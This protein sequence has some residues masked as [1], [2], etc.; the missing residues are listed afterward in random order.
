MVLVFLGHLLY[1]SR[2]ESNKNRLVELGV[3]REAIFW[4]CFKDEVKNMK[5]NDW[6]LNN[7]IAGKYCS[8]LADESEEGRLM[9]KLRS[10][11]PVKYLTD[12]ELR[13]KILEEY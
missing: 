5:S 12:T 13:I 2:L 3:V 7:D 8:E 10:K 11:I 9:K 4:K 6:M 1:S